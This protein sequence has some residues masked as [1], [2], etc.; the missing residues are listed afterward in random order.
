MKE[1]SKNCSYF[2]A[3]ISEIGKEVLMTGGVKRP[4]IK[5]KCYDSNEK[6]AEI[7]IVFS[8]ISQIRKAVAYEVGDVIYISSYIGE[9]PV[10][11]IVFYPRTVHVLKKCQMN[12]DNFSES[13]VKSRL[14]PYMKEPN[15]VI[16]EG[17]I[18]VTDGENT[19]ILIK[20]PEILRGDC[21]S[22]SHIWVKHPFTNLKAEDK[23]LFMGDVTGEGL[24]G[25]LYKKE[26]FE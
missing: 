25:S 2:V 23:V 13:F 16:F 12:N 26:F 20:N 19:S 7:S 5:A 17:K 9:C 10:D 6:I 15:R 1:E 3:V 14:I 22:E 11:N 24:F 8:S 21:Q 18:C 4:I